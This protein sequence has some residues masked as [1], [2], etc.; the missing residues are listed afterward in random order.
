MPCLTDVG[1]FAVL[2]NRGFYNSNAQPESPR[3]LPVRR[4]FTHVGRISQRFSSVSYSIEPNP[5]FDAQRGACV[6]P[7]PQP[8]NNPVSNIHTVAYSGRIFAGFECSNRVAG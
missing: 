5:V 3:S 4:T 2:G 7:R 6:H 1:Y 8:Y